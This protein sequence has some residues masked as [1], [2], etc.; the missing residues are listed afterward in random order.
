MKSMQRALMYDGL[1]PNFM[2]ADGKI[3]LGRPD[4]EDVHKMTRFVHQEVGT[5][6]P[7]DII[8]EGETNPSKPETLDTVKAYNDAG[9]TWWIEA[10]WNATN[11][12]KIIDRIESGPPQI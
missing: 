12:A 11:V 2:G 4:L 8:L 9:A 3:K 10:C 6:R 7:F 1:L 5:N